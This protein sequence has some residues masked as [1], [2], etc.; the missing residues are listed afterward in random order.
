M[1]I[2]HTGQEV[3]MLTHGVCGWG[4][5]TEEERE[6]RREERTYRKREVRRE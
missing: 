5:V 3:K 6:R 4:M 1:T 2:A